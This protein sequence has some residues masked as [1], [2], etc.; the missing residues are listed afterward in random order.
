MNAKKNQ[1]SLGASTEDYDR[2]AH[3]YGWY[4]PEVLFGMCFEYLQ[5]GE[6]LLD[7]GIGSG[8]CAS[9]FCKAGLQ[10]FGL[11]ISLEMLNIVRSKGFVSDLKQ[12]NICTKPW[13]Y[14]D[15]CFNHLVACGVLH[16]MD[17]LALIFME[18]TR[19][20]QAGGLFAFTT[21]AT[22][23]D[24]RSGASKYS[25][26]IING[27]TIF[28]HQKA[29]LEGLIATCGFEKLKDLQFMVGVDQTGQRDPFDALV[30]RK[31]NSWKSNDGEP[32]S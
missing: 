15:S 27:F 12:F 23:H 17:D 18:A 25:T 5:P 8:L 30:T 2:L 28:S 11:D 26:E 22:Q 1:Q 10:V 6:R 21:K 32:A 16:F 4:G 19:V 24:T 7:I 29:Y 14:P 31:V 13:P 20:M 3:E 9:L